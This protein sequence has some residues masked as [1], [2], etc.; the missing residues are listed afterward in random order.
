MTTD[1]SKKLKQLLSL[2]D[3]Q[4]LIF[5]E[6]LLNKGFSSDLL[7]WYRKSGWIESYERGIYKKTNTEITI[8]DLIFAMQNQLELNIFFAGKYCLS[9]YYKISHFVSFNDEIKT[10]FFYNSQK[11]LP[12]WFKKKFEKEINFYQTDFIKTDKGFITFDNIKIPSKERAFLE[13][14]YL[15]PEKTSVTE[16]KEILELMPELRPAFLQEL[17]EKCS[18]IKV[19][20]LFLYLAEEVNHSWYKYLKTEKIDLG[21]GVREVEL[22][23]TYIKKYQIIVKWEEI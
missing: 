19:K 21:K 6:Q 17:L 18:S 3:S 4:K 10:L 20:R 5:S 16:A 7:Q 22:D 11:K 23:G 8:E 2:F 13:L 15:C 1:T 14:L 9:K 12:S